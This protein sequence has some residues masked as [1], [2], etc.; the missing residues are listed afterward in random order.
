[1]N[2]VKEKVTPSIFAAQ[3]FWR[4]KGENIKQLNTFSSVLGEE[5]VEVLPH[6]L[7]TT[8]LSVE[9]LSFHGKGW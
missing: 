4:K 3:K 5:V 7:V 8:S 6:G 9:N 1:M 2:C